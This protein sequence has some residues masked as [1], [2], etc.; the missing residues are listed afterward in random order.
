MKTL[1]MYRKGGLKPTGGPAGYLY[2]ISVVIDKSRDRDIEFLGDGCFDRLKQFIKKNMIHPD[3]L[4]KREIEQVKNKLSWDARI[5]D[6][7][8]E[9][10]KIHSRINLE[11]Y[12]IIH[13]HNT[14]DMY[15]FKKDLECYKGV[16]ILT[17]H[18]PKVYYKEIIED[19]ITNKE[20][21][22]NKD[23]Y[24]R[25]EEFDTYAFERA[26]F[27]IFPC[28]GA[29]EPYF[30]SWPAYEKLRDPSK[31]RYISTGILP[32]ECKKNKEE[33]RRELNIPQDATILSFVGRHNEVK[34]YDI[35]KDI[36]SKLDNVYVVCC[37]KIGNIRPP[38]SNRWIE[39]GWTTDPYSYVG[40]SDIYMLP[41]RE[42]YFDIAMLQTLSI[43]KCSVISNT[44]GNKEFAKT[45]GVKLY[46]TIDEAVSC[47]KE[48]ILMPT[49]EKTNLEHLQRQ[50]FKEKYTIEVFYKKYKEMLRKLIESRKDVI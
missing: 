48:L 10:E 12:D 37:G 21:E 25:A 2:N 13:F 50:E 32:V 7:T 8:Q 11:P 30:H 47:I 15:K 16:V 1:I 5:L 4:K 28:P 49:E 41:N 42:T 3:I 45:P 36:F 31:I 24:D 17:S 27:I 19:V 20:Y 29:E 14:F 34:G 40:A 18:S 35:L 39:V 26:D 9:A 6:I 22:D 38:E 23:T 44:G 46:D 43:G 33:I